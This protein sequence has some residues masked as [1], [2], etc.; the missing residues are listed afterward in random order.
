MRESAAHA[1]PAAPAVRLAEDAEAPWASGRRPSHARRFVPF[2]LAAALLAFV[3]ARIDFRSFA[4]ALGRVNHVGFVLFTAVWLG[5]LLVCDGFGSHVAYRVA[6]RRVGLWDLVLFRSASY[7][8]GLLNYHVS[9]G[10]LTYV[11]AKLGGVPIARMAGATLLSYAGW[12][13]CLLGCVAIALPFA[14]QPIVYSVGIVVAGLAYL[15]L[16]AAR[17]GWL[18]ERALLAPLFEAGLTGHLVALLARLP[19]FAW[20]AFGHWVALA[21][22]GVHV[23]VLDALV[24]IPILLVVSTL[25]I[26][27]QGFGTRDAVAGAFFAPIAPGDSPEAR[28]AQVA[29]CT[30]SWGVLLTLLSALIG[31]V[32]MRFVERRLALHA[33]AEGRAGAAAGARSTAS[34]QD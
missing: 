27:P 28:L 5:A 13:G 12:F 21:F 19:H 7:L 22:F 34:P 10:F 31:V 11:L 29:A 30:T 9:Q 26:T 25:P 23:P 6:A 18:A 33:D 2:L 1:E 8:P 16:V 14:G 15:G 24:Q 32:A 3:L 17:P 20:L 4:A